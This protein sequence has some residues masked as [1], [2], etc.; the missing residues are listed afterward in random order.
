MKSG[1]RIWLTGHLRATSKVYNN[2]I[3]TY[4]SL[5][6]YAEKETNGPKIDLLEVFA[7]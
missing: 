2:E 5:I 7:G 4:E 6:T 3:S 1:T